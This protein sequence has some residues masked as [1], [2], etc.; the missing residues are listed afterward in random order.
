MSKIQ[1]NV[2]KRFM[3]YAGKSDGFAVTGGAS[4]TDSFVINDRADFFVDFIVYSCTSVLLLV[5]LQISNQKIF[6]RSIKIDLIAGSGLY[7]NFIPKGV[8][9]KFPM[10]SNVSIDYTDKSNS[11]NTVY[12][13]FIG[14]EVA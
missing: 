5:Q 2:Y 1:S 6:D 13:A 12:L 10:K 4:G 7:A 14:H 11:T 3:V 9:L 8:K